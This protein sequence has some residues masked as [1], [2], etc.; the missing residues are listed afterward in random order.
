MNVYD[1]WKGMSK[2]QLKHELRFAKL[3]EDRYEMFL[4]LNLLGKYNDTKTD[5]HSINRNKY[6]RVLCPICKEASHKV[7]GNVKEQRQ[8]KNGHIFTFNDMNRS[9]VYKVL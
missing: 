5:S 3:R 8:C 1:K 4:L 7:K 9:A 6:E 2:S